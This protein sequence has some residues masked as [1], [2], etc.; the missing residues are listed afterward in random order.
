MARR[1]TFGVAATL[2]LG[3]FLM[4]WACLIGGEKL[5]HRGII[6]PW[7]GMWVANIVLSL[8][9]V[10]L[11]VRMARE[12]PRIQWSRIRRLVPKSWRSPEHP[13]NGDEASA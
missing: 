12:T 2:S 13:E 4:Y 11:T 8:L 10:Y 3:F 7:F 5:A 9:G 6:A 1:G